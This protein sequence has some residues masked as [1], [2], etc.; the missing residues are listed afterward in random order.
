M[1]PAELARARGVLGL[2]A[3][4]LAVDLH[5]SEE[6]IHHWEAGRSTVPAVYARHIAWRAALAERDA[7][8]AASG[9]PEC[10]WVGRWQREPA[11]RKL[12]S[13]LRR[14]EKLQQHRQT[15][16]TCQ[17]RQ[18]YVDERFPPLP[19][20]PLSPGLQAVRNI[21]KVIERLPQAA[22]PVAIGALVGISLVLLRWVFLLV[23]A[24]PTRQVFTLG[25]RALL[26][27]ALAGAMGGIAYSV[28]RGPF[29]RL[30]RPGYYLSA[31]TAGLTAFGT[32][33]T[34][35][36][37][38]TDEPM[39]RQPIGWILLL[40]LGVLIGLFVGHSWAKDVTESDDAAD[41]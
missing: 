18:R 15:C 35:I 22:R 19:D 13:R 5:L 12:A 10:D 23:R 3:E 36:V 37:L 40:G 6:T 26:A 25:G 9:L 21:S 29:H 11:P 7:A 30:G 4:Q 28:V 14:L 41:A 17:T 27:G 16:V 8:L 20:P 32:M 39:L 1:T 33:G 31:V 38:F 24:G 2:S 34:I